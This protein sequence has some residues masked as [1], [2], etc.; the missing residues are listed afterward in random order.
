MEIYRYEGASINPY[1]YEYKEKYDTY[2]S[3]PAAELK[4]FRYTLFYKFDDYEEV[5]KKHYIFKKFY[6]VK[7]KRV[8]YV[9]YKKGEEHYHTGR[10]GAMSKNLNKL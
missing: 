1:V 7:L 10:S 2:F 8:V 9:K 3:I 6:S 4:D 5:E